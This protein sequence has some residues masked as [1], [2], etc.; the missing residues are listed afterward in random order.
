MLS[1]ADEHVEA[2]RSSD[3][4]TTTFQRESSV[5]RHIADYEDNESNKRQTKPIYKEEIDID[6]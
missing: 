2:P 1:R 5:K 3:D 6:S 4:I